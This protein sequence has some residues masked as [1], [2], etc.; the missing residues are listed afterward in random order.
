MRQDG[1]DD[2]DVVIVGCGV[3]GLC[4]V[5]AAVKVGAIVTILERAAPEDRGGNAR[6]TEACLRMKSMEEVSD[7]FE[8]SPIEIGSINPDPTVVAGLPRSYKNWPSYV[9]AHFLLDS[10][11]LA[12]F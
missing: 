8:V 9:I 1:T 11:R 2:C 6:L 12:L 7:D 5:A 3:A 4:T 10:E